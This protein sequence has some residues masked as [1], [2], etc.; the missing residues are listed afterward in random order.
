MV[1]CG[2]SR[3]S[4]KTSEHT[5]DTDELARWPLVVGGGRLEVS[6]AGAASLGGWTTVAGAG[7]VRTLDGRICSNPWARATCSM[8]LKYCRLC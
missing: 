4:P 1:G 6:I 8:D 7:P 2:W 3:S 5:D